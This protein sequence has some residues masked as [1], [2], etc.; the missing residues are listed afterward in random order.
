VFR[1][2]RLMVQ[3][4]L[5]PAQVLRSATVNGARLLG[6]EA[7]L[8]DVAAGKLADLVLLDAD[9]HASVDNLARARLVFRGGRVFDPAALIESIR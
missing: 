1:E 8:G 3:A 4:G 7:D 5:T 9:P 2:A 6:L